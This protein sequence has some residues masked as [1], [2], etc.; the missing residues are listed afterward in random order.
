M[1]QTVP[2]NLFS[3]VKSHNFFL[4]LWIHK[5]ASEEDICLSMIAP[6]HAFF[7]H[8][9]SEIILKRQLVFVWVSVALIQIDFLLNVMP[10]LWNNKYMFWHQWFSLGC[11]K[12]GSLC[13]YNCSPNLTSYF[14]LL[15]RRESRCWVGK[16]GSKHVKN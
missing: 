2:Q 14:A 9:G 1:I 8:Q 15:L 6:R 3:N 16:Y 4:S 13:W 5:I 7:L 10:N 11:L 12:F